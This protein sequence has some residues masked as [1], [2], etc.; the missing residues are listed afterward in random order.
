MQRRQRQG[1]GW[2]RDGQMPVVCKGCHPLWIGEIVLNA[3]PATVVEMFTVDQIEAEFA[4]TDQVDL[5]ML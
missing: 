5:F 2:R 4:F 3:P 1:I